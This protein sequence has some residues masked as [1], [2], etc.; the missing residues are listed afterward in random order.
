MLRKEP[1]ITFICSETKALE[2]G[3][4]PKEL[5][6]KYHKLHC[7][8]Y[9]WFNLDFDYFGQTSTDSQTRIAQ[10]IFK[11]IHERG[12]TLEKTVEQL[13]CSKCDRFLSDRFVEGTCPKCKYNDARGDQCDNCTSLLNPTE[14]IDPRCKVCSSKPELRQ[15][16]HIYIDLPKLEPQLQEFLDNAWEKNEWTPNCVAVTNSWIKGGLQSRAITRD[17]KW[18]TPV[19][20]EKFKDKVFYVWFDAPIGYI[21]ITAEYAP[22]DWEKW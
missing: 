6:D 20:L 17:L 3:V 15:S 19:P 2:E 7:E 10:D 1:I 11:R 21:S 16:E 8:I 12:Y 13:Y 5:C 18:G 22:N 9:K 14:L 4:T